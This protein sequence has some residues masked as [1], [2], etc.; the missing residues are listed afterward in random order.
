MHR[1]I[2]YNARAR[3]SRVNI[4]LATTTVK[5][6]GLPID[7]ALPA[8]RAALLQRNSAVLSAPPGAGKSTV[9]PLVLLKESWA[10]G[11]K[12]VM[13]E[14][15][16]LAAR[17]VAQR[18][19]SQL[20]E[21]VGGVVGYRMRLDTRVSQRTRIE[22]I[23]EGVLTRMLHTDA[24]L[25]GVAALLFDEFH[26][27]SLHADLAMALALAARAALSTDLRIVAMSATLDVARVA[28]LLGD[29]P[30][31]SA[32]GRM[33]PVSVQHLGAG[34]PVLPGGPPPDTPE[35]LTTRAVLQA[36][37]E[38]SGDVLVFLPGGAEIRRVAT[39]L[40]EALAGERG[41]GVALRGVV[42]VLPLYGDLPPAEQ[43]AALA[44]PPTGT[45][46]VI[47][48]TNIAETS[49]T[50]QGVRVVVDAG[51]VRQ[52]HF[53]PV[54]GMTRLE[55]VRIS[56]ASAEQRGGR[57][58]R[59][60]PGVC[61][62]LWSAGAERSLA[63]FDTPEIL[64][65]DL[66]ALALDLALWGANDSTR[67]S[68]LDAPPQAT[69]ASSRD[70]LQ[71]LGALDSNGRISSHGREL[72]SV[73]A[74]PRLVQLLLVARARGA[75][76]LGAQLCA[77]LGE[78]DI[79]RG[80]ARERGADVQPR[81]D[82]LLGRGEA[83][84]DRGAVERVRRSTTQF[85]RSAANIA[86]PSNKSKVTTAADEPSVGVLLAQAYPDRI[87][88]R[89]SAPA[90]Q[91]GARFLLSNGRGAAFS[92]PELLG[93]S[94]FIVA[95]ELDD[96]DREA[97]ILLAAPITRAEIEAE[98]ATQLLRRDVVE[99]DAREELVRARRV[100]EFGALLLDDRP[101]EPA[102]AERTQAA[103]L[104][105]VVQMGI[106]SLPWDDEAREFCARANF[107]RQLASQVAEPWPDFSSQALL[108][109][110]PDWLSPW[111]NDVM[112]RAHLA[113]LP[114]QDA[115]RARLP[116]S[117]QRK[118][119]E[120]AP[121]HLQVPTGTRLR[122]DYRDDL[123][124]CVS[125]RMQEVYGLPV[126]PHIGGGAVP[127]TFKLLSP[128]QRPLQVTRDLA[129]FW[130]NAYVE[131]RKDM[132][133]RYPRHNWPENPLQAEPTRGVKRRR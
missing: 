96:L 66:T 99:W 104:G 39:Q 17:A 110:L 27:R 73:A 40:A 128:A 94:E 25:E 113:R 111:L 131:V 132:R 86:V 59:T 98:F 36:L 114:L 118:L 15:R 121:T 46:R 7:A 106:E 95:V 107:A 115:L 88:K 23:T 5:P 53:D 42:Q 76:K 1:R 9:V 84:V 109:T 90:A 77:L 81:L 125:V 3:N 65:A 74:H 43:D 13:L 44:P 116:Q 10:R 16:R 11:R 133:G 61:Y 37:R 19:A 32:Q 97:R 60:E 29:A 117:L 48:A 58:G 123:A 85:E 49:L 87:G 41:P 47:L 103:M 93:K 57:A 124:P 52:S 89:R 34:M 6:T 8:L 4:S 14:P 64:Q 50:I 83:D 72:A 120:L 30:V 55:T 26:E 24:A 35:R 119:D 12:L 130:R 100:T 91:Q 105:G 18:M 102:P 92:G 31:V 63:A 71:R 129:S 45:R 68:W 75:T 28:K 70:L 62:R 108:D 51:L 2:T 79:L 127:V 22:V 80:P 126:T 101:L 78:R 21:A 82:A 122:I 54:T 67:L 56:R 38:E 112:R 33:F 69:L 20:G